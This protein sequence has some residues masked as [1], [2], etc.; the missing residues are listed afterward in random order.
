VVPSVAVL[1]HS[2]VTSLA[3]TYLPEVTGLVG[4]HCP[5]ATRPVGMT[6]PRPCFCG[7]KYDGGRCNRDNCPR[8][9]LGNGSWHIALPK[10]QDLWSKGELANRYP[11]LDLAVLD[12]HVRNSGLAHERRKRHRAQMAATYDRGRQRDRGNRSKRCQRNDQ[13]DNHPRVWRQPRQP[14]CNSPNLASSS[15]SQLPIKLEPDVDGASTGGDEDGSA[16]GYA[17]DI[18]IL[19]S[20][21]SQASIFGLRSALHEVED[22]DELS[23]ASSQDNDEKAVAERDSVKD[24][25]ADNFLQYELDF[26]YVFVDFEEAYKHAGRAV[27]VAWSRARICKLRDLWL[28]ET[29]PWKASAVASH[30][31]S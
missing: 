21:E 14:D 10:L 2:E 24:W 5:E 1:C 27:A 11:Q 20:D 4:V 8:A 17:S 13:S 18:T 6:K 3:N 28:E 9:K 16:A 26:A 12:S 29:Q 7:N 23:E 22:E 25:R 31:G 30:L 15:T 19:D